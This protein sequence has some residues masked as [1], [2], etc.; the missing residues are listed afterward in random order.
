MLM[1]VTPSSA[2]WQEA[3]GTRSISAHHW[4]WSDRYLFPPLLG[5][6]AAA[7]PLTEGAIGAFVDFYNYRRYHK[8]LGN[9]TPADVLHGHREVI[10]ARRKEVQKE[11]FERRRQYNQAVREAAKMGAPPP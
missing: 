5:E 1:P 10:L 7:Q 2:R 6:V 8:A 4:N 9:V 3:S 11:T